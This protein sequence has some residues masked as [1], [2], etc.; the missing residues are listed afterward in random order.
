[1][2]KFL[3]IVLISVLVFIVLLI[4]LVACSDSDSSGSSINSEVKEK[5]VLKKED[6][7]KIYTDPEKYKGYKVKLTGQVFSE[8]EKDDE[9]VYF[10]MFGDPEN[11]EKNTMV[12]SKDT[13]LKLKGDQY[14]E[15]EGI[16][17]DEFE[18]ENAFG[19]EVTAAAVK[20]SKVKVIDFITATSPTQKTIDV[21]KTIDQQGLVVQVQKVELAKNQT[22]VFVKITNNSK[23]DASFYSSESKLIVNNKQLETE[24]LDSEESGL[25]EVQSE[26][27]PNIENEGVLIYPALPNDTKQVKLS[28][29]ASTED[30]DVEFQPYT[31]DVTLKWNN[32]RC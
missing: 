31:F 2:K 21:G 15:V 19:G 13:S 4:L 25:Q 24:Y 12:A 28:I 11:S 27:L 23:M 16:I 22:R 1:M 10:Q 29:D 8:P 20:A 26:M 6:Y 14:V 7:D 30:Y 9:G 32:I 5:G 18:G 17:V 3:K